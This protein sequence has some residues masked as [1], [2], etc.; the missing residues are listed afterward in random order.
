MYSPKVYKALT[1][2]GVAPGIALKV[3]YIDIVQTVP[4][5]I[6]AFIRAC[7]LPLPLF[8]FF[9][10]YTEFNLHLT[11]LP[12]SYYLNRVHTLWP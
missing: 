12:P 1:K 5:I 3:R 10:I 11:K 6:L 9:V 2:E 8:N 7:I 4:G